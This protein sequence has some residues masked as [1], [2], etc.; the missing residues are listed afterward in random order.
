MQAVCVSVSKC[1]CVCPWI[2]M[3][4]CPWI[5]LRL[6][7]TVCVSCVSVYKCVCKLCLSV[8]NYVRAVGK[9]GCVCG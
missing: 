5:S 3:C 2:N 7:V 9:C 4:V 8:G 6:W 1:V